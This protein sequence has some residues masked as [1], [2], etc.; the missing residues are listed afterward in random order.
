MAK[1]FQAARFLAKLQIGGS[2]KCGKGNGSIKDNCTTDHNS[3]SYRMNNESDSFEGSVTLTPLRVVSSEVD[4]K[5]NLQKCNSLFAT[6]RADTKMSADRTSSVF[7]DSSAKP[8]SKD[9]HE[10]F[11]S[12][13]PQDPLLRLSCLYDPKKLEPEAT[14]IMIEDE[15]QEQQERLQC[16]SP[17]ESIGS[18]DSSS[19][20]GDTESNSVIE[21]EI[22]WDDLQLR[23]EIG[24][25]NQFCG[26]VLLPCHYL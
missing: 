5:E 24:Q 15:V 7:K 11:A 21:C 4:K 10:C 26:C 1:S 16:P 19:S 22:H 14:N 9:S 20:K 6:E 8:F 3:G 2:G 17:R 12:P 25:G 13:F 23:E 18:H